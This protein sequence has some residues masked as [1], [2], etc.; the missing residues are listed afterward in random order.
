M[1]DLAVTHSLSQGSWPCRPPHWTA[2]AATGKLQHIYAKTRASLPPRPPPL[3]AEPRPAS[4]SRRAA[5]SGHRAVFALQGGYASI[6]LVL[7]ASPTTLLLQP[8]LGR[9]LQ[10]SVACPGVPQ[11]ATSSPL[12]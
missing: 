1:A 4:Y 3:P 10:P 12:T 2:A 7:G 5:L 6:L 9:L 11:Q 8:L